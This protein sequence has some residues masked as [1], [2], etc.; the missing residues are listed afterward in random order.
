MSMIRD[1]TGAQTLLGYVVDLTDGVARSILDI[2]PQH[3]NRHG[4]L[5]GGIMAAM[6]DNAMGY[7]AALRY[8]PDAIPTVM[9]VSMTT[10]YIA[11]VREGTVTATGTVTGGGRSILFVDGALT[12]EDGRLLATATGVFKRIK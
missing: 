12:A 9:T 7:A 10:S 11:P 4:G 2:G 8:D 3:T 1:E 6:L 5:H